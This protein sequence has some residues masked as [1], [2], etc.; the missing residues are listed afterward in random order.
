MSLMKKAVNSI[1]YGSQ[2]VMR[3]IKYVLVKRSKF[4]E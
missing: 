2:I 1:S 4:I 3:Y